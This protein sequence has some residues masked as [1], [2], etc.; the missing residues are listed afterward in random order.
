MSRTST[1]LDIA[2]LPFAR[3]ISLTGRQ[4]RPLSTDAIERQMR[5][6]AAAMM[7][8]IELLAR[9]AEVSVRRTIVRCEPIDALAAACAECGPSHV[10]ALAEPLT[11]ADAE[12]L[13]RLFRTLPPGTGL[14]AIGP[15]ASRST[16]PIV[17][18]VDDIDQFEPVLRAARLLF[19]ASSVASFTILMAAESDAEADVMEQQARLALGSDDA[20]EIVHARV[21]PNAPAMVAELLRRLNAGFIVSHFG[22]IIV[23]PDGDLRELISLLQCPLLLIR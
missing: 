7:R 15:T 1:L 9:N 17:G 20:V 13:R 6:A 11:G 16:G 5:Q 23:P 12:L 8:E 14:L 18:V 19:D 4:S 21:L 2:G 10:I 3:E 22:G